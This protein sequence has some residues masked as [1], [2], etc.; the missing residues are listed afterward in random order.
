MKSPGDGLESRMEEMEGKSVN[1]KAVKYNI[2]S[3]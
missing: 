1:W 3:A 2:H